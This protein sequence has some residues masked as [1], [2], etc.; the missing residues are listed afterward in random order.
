MKR[1]TMHHHYLVIGLLTILTLIAGCKKEKLNPNTDERLEGI[2]SHNNS[3]T[4]SFNIL[5]QLELNADGS[6][7]ESTFRITN[8][9]GDIPDVATLKWSVSTDN[10]LTLTFDNGDAEVYTYEL[11]ADQSKLILTDASHVSREFFLT[12]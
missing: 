8:F 5:T 2:W 12:D 1:E 9:G 10:K 4:P 6:G 11:Q 7:T 3:I